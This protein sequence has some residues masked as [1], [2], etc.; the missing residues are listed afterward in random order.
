MK[1]KLEIRSKA[2][3]LAVKRREKKVK[4]GRR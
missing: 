2:S 4:R 3:Y 1:T